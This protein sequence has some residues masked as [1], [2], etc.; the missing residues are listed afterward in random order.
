MDRQT[1]Y[2]G[3]IPLETDLLNTNKNTMIAL[4]KQSLL[5]TGSA[6]VIHGLNCTPTSPASLSVNIGAG[7]I[8]SMQNI[9]STAYSSLPADTAHSISKQGLALNS[10][11]FTLTAPATSGQ[12]INYLIQAIY[13]DVDSGSTVLPYYNAANPSVA[14]SG[15][16]NSGAAQNTVRAGVC[17]VTVKTG[18]A[19]ATGM[20][21][22]PTPDAGYVGA[23]VITVA[24]GQTT[25]T[26]SSISLAPNAPFLPSSGIVA[27]IQNNALTYAIDTGTANSY[28]VSY[29]PPVTQLTDGM[30]LSFKAKNTNTTSSTISIN[31]LSSV[32]L[33]SQS[34]QALQGGEVI[35][36][37]IVEF[38]W[39]SSLSAFV[40]TCNTGGKL[41]VPTATGSN[42]A[43]NLAQMNSA[44]S[45]SSGPFISAF[46]SNGTF[47]VPSGVTQIKITCTGGG[48]GGGGRQATSNA[49]PFS[50]SGGGAGA[51]SIG[52]Y[53]VSPGATLAVTVGAGGAGGVGAT[54]GS[55]GSSSSV[56]S[57][58]VGGGGGFGGWGS[59][60]SSA[61]GTGGTATGGAVNIAGGFGGDGQS[62]VNMLSGYG[63]ASYFGGG[64][65]ASSTTPV[66]VLVPGAG[67]GG[68]YDTSFTGTSV[69]GG[70]GANGVVIIEW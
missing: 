33:Y 46:T 38:V 10:Q 4:A 63:G 50:G 15:P 5:L 35:S 41:Q 56:G 58:C 67:G 65:R 39:N 14:W 51:T 68:S 11:V 25:I 59:S 30:M 49:G 61:G 55:N 29:S 22:T 7:S 20:Q 47:T 6:T 32:P 24:N 44:I 27:G 70:S 12:S 17:N 54:S 40:L 52:V 26:S 64:A 48:G 31:G 2:A 19:A 34:Q 23:W 9:D 37:G 69:N 16:A 8:Y 60:V 18:V 45:A 43:V 57:L 53:T 36:N 28:V 66:T 3:A 13:Q 62:G 21:S 42:Q 1:V